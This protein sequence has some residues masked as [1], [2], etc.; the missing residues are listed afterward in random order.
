[1]G[2]EEQHNDDTSDEG[3]HFED[4][5]SNLERPRP[6]ERT[7]RQ[8]RAPTEWWKTQQTHYA[9]IA[10]SEEPQSYKEA[11]E[12]KNA[13]EWKAAMQAEYKSLMDNETWMLCTLPANR[14]AIG[15]RWILKKLKADGTLDK[16]KARVA[17]HR[18]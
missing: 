11:M 17:A 9:N 7:Q 13:D 5:P 1:M 4:A 3:E 18:S 10:T 14:K 8:R 16:Y 12:N 2:E 15:C 6:Q